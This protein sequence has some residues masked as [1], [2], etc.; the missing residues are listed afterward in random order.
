MGLRHG[1]PSQTGVSN[2]PF[3]AA[4]VIQFSPSGWAWGISRGPGAALPGFCPP[5]LYCRHFVA[6]PQWGGFA[7]ALQELGREGT[8]WG[9]RNPGKPLHIEVGSGGRRLPQTWFCNDLYRNKCTSA[10]APFPVSPYRAG[11][12]LAQGIRPPQDGAHTF[13]VGWALTHKQDGPLFQLASESCILQLG[14]RAGS[15]GG[16][17]GVG[18]PSQAHLAFPFLPSP[19]SVT[20]GRSLSQSPRSLMTEMGPHT[21]LWGE[22]RS[23]D[24]FCST[25]ASKGQLRGTKTVT[26]VLWE[27]L[28][29]R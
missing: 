4:G 5:S 29:R 20:L 1:D 18:F 16:W 26:Q 12:S 2:S 10:P 28:L 21:A 24:R 13:Q 22:D 3:A 15:S 9:R 17:G 19:I 27:G 25:Q 7:P 14:W 11:L 23:H 6:G 8:R